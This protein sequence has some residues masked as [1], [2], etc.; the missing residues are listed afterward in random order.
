MDVAE[1]SDQKLDLFSPAAHQAHIVGPP[2]DTPSQWHIAGGPLVGRCC[3][4]AGWIHKHGH[5]FITGLYMV[6]VGIT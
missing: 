5:L 6:L 4:L 3:E 2:S 1:G